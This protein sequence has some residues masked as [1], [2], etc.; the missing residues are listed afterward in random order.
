[1]TTTRRP[2]TPPGPPPGDGPAGLDPRIRARRIEVRRQ[3]GRRRLRVLLGVLLA[4]ALL[5]LGYVVAG[6]ALLDVDDLVVTGNARTPAADIVTASDLAPGQPLLLLDVDGASAAIGRLPWVATAEVHRSITGT[7]T[8]EVVERQP[9]ATLPTTD[10]AWVVVDGEG[11]QLEQ[12][13]APG[14]DQLVLRGVEATGVV[15]TPVGP[16]PQEVLRLL[17]ALTPPVRAAVSGI[18]LDGTELFLELAAGGRVRLGDTSDLNDKL[19]SLETMLARVDLRCLSELDL[20]VPSAPALSRR[21]PADGDPPAP[22]SDS[23]NCP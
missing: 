10:G 11:R 20:E 12:V 13:A 21:P 17:D 2:P 18:G 7:V 16:G 14:P 6:S 1:M 22:L 4:A 5:G 8:I 3:Q 23:S 19:V 9:V 15:G